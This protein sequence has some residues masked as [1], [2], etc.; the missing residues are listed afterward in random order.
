MSSY[1]ALAAVS[2][3]LDNL[4]KDRMNVMA[5]SVR[6]TV[7]VTFAPPDSASSDVIA[8]EV[9]VNL[10]LYRVTENAHL[11]NQEIPGTGSRGAYGLP[12]LSLDLHYLMT[13]S[14]PGDPIHA[15][16]SDI[17]SQIVLGEAMRVLHDF[18]IVTGSLSHIA[19][20]QEGEIGDP[21]LD[22]ELEDA[23]EQIKISLEPFSLDDLSKIWSVFPE[24]PFRRCVGYHVSVIQIQSALPRGISRP[25]GDGE[26]DEARGGR[27]VVSI[28]LGRPWITALRIIRHGDATQRERTAP[29]ARVGD[30]LVLHGR[31]LGRRG[32]KIRISDLP[33]VDPTETSDDR[34]TFLLSETTLPGVEV[35][36]VSLRVVQTV[37]F[38]VE[39]EDPRLRD[40][41]DSNS[42]VFMPVP[43]VDSA[44]RNSTTDIVTITGNRLLAGELESIALVGGVT[45]RAVDYTSAAEAQITF[46]LSD[47]DE[48]LTGNGVWVR[49]GAAQSIDACRLEVTA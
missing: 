18:P 42:I 12:P 21:I 31:N 3:T 33:A 44:E 38:S 9:R 35:G 23:F 32:T 45:V 30:T 29:Y 4:L 20:S 1:E 48:E 36:P 15:G 40:A 37:D 24:T 28:P 41:L 7:D 43:R 22:A 47:P 8:G 27:R 26:G 19:G 49:V 17:S 2:R 14:G 39:G 5:N 13:A 6:Q 25:V 16:D 46:H 10:Y 34:L 11:K